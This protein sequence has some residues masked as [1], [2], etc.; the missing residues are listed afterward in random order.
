M[1]EADERIVGNHVILDIDVS[2]P[3]ELAKAKAPAGAQIFKGP[4]KT[5]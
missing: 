5:E 2:M 1:P 4:L 3:F